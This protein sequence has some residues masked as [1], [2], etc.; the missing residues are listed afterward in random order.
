MAADHRGLA[1]QDSLAHGLRLPRSLMLLVLLAIAGTSF[2]VPGQG[3]ITLERIMADPLWIADTP[4]APYWSADSETVYFFRNLQDQDDRELVAIKLVGGDPQAVDLAALATAD[5]AGGVWSADRQHK[6]YQRHGDVFVR[7]LASGQVI[8]LTRTADEE[9]A[10]LFTADGRGV[11]FS[12]QQVVL[13]RDLASGLEHQAADLRNEAAP[14]DEDDEPADYLGQQQLDLF[15]S[16]RRDKAKRQAHRQRQHQQRAADASLGPEPWYL[17]EEIEVTAAALSP[18]TEAML[19]TLQ[20]A[21]AQLGER[22]NLP[23]FVT[24]D[25]YVDIEEVRPKVGSG[26]PIATQL[27]LLDL[28]QHQRHDLDLDLLEGIR[29][30]PLAELRHAAAQRRQEAEDANANAETAAD[31]VDSDLVG[32]PADGGPSDRQSRRQKKAARRAAAQQASEQASEQ[33]EDEP[34]QRAVTFEGLSWSPDGRHA[35]LHALSADNKDRWT[36]L[37]TPA[38][39]QPLRVIHRLSDEGWI[40][41]HHNELGWLPDSSGFFL[42]SEATGYSQLYLYD[43]EAK[44]LRQLTD[45]QQVV[46]YPQASAD[47]RRLY[48]RSNLHHPGIYETYRVAVEG[49]EPEQLTELGGTSR[50][51]LSPDGERLLIRQSS[52]GRPP[53]L[54]VQD[55]RPGAP[56]RRLTH[57][58]SEEFE[59]LPWVE[60][61]FVKVPSSHQSRPI[62]GRLY[63][64]PA[65]ARTAV[66]DG[67]RPAVMFVHGA[68]Y[69]QNAHQGWSGYFREFMFHS[70]LAHHGYLVLDLDYRASRGYGRD[71][72]TAIYRQMGT[73]ELEDYVDGRSWLIDNHAVDPG[74]IGIYGGS[75]GGF[76]T[77]MALFKTPELFAAGA[78]LRPV[79]DWA[80]YNHGY[81][82]AILN[83]PEIDPEAY[84]R[85]SPIEFAEGLTKP[86]LI[87]HGMLDDNV[88]FL[89]TV[90][91]AQRL[92]ELEKENW[93][94]AI[95]PQER[96]GFR[97]P[98]SWLN[99]YRR[100]FALFERHLW[101]PHPGAL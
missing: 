61:I 3:P 47:S 32:K 26:E 99:E 75:Y 89:D 52:A 48:Y 64:P 49:G 93:E 11:I 38:A 90:R 31:P 9:S 62:Y 81:T 59:S 30:D 42:L 51:W 78:S 50:S 28:V 55:A 10:A 22:D 2:A 91:L 98:A 85:S 21:A 82:S 20:P 39:E 13:V 88:L 71:W 83:T 16:L 87:C 80:H 94:V 29:Q 8:Q 58:V 1:H 73:P 12:R 5:T 86:L 92:I 33:D 84:A 100:I 17:G 101:P 53:E 6:V 76:M 27:V 14:E 74:R 65:E 54:F 15:D 35:V 95:Y 56:T 57:T 60:P 34:E 4:L 37:V 72:R 25:G 79:T 63:L 70:L 45:G 77:F 41:W 40:N 46:E 69:L 7:H 97:R 96:H 19:I 68:G 18:S 44:E 43:L 66:G 23:V 67:P 24:E 36:L